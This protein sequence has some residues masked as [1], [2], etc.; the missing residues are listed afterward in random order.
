M[1]ALIENLV[2]LQTIELNRARL[3]QEMR[4]LPA[5]IARAE[6]AL[7]AAERQSADASAALSREDSL[8][9]RLEREI[10]AHRQKGARFRVQLDSVTT[11]AQAA[12]IEHEI[13]F[14]TAEV[15]RLENDEYASLE[16]S[17]AQEAALAQARAD[18]ERLAAEAEA[19]RA[20]VAARKQEA[21]RR[22]G[23]SRR[24][25]RSRPRSSRCR[26][27]GAI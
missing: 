5:E 25:P 11:P 19:V 18:V 12:A 26:L 21:R 8:R 14:A 7:A 6:A 27:A 22:V 20:N 3:N 17:E 1:Q 4:A 13:Q 16:R 2:K 24:G 15:E 23:R 9:T 10:D